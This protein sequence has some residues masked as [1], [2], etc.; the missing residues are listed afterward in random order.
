MGFLR[1]IA[2]EQRGRR[3]AVPAGVTLRPTA[4]RVREALFNILAP[5]VSGARVLDAYAGSGALGFEALSRGAGEVLFIEADR[6]VQRALRETAAS[7]GVQDRCRVLG[8]RVLDLLARGAV[9]GRYDLI[10]ADPPYAG[11]EAE[12]F[13]DAAGGLLAADGLLVLERPSGARPLELPSVRLERVRQAR[14]GTSSLEF[15]AHSESW[16]PVDPPGGP[17]GPKDG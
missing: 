9:G 13:L 16:K 4:D 17:F 12:P 2:G 14:Y 7:L 3:I 1:V 10:L 15:Y 6:R 5:I 11:G 8:G